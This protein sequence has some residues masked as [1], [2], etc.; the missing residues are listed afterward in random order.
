[1]AWLCLSGEELWLL[2]AGQGFW[3]QLVCEKHHLCLRTIETPSQVV[4]PSQSHHPHPGP[5]LQ[6]VCDG[7]WG[8][9]KQNSSFP[10]LCSSLTRRNFLRLEMQKYL[11]YQIGIPGSGC[12]EC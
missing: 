10:G 3:G 6:G 11:E 4:S 7:G 2:G 9:R 8:F 1:M 5:G 12:V